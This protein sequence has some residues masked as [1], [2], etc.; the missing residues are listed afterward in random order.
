MT[1][2][3]KEYSRVFTIGRERVEVDY[4]DPTQV[5]I[6]APQRLASRIV[7]VRFRAGRTTMTALIELRRT[8][9]GSL[10]RVWLPVSLPANAEIVSLK[11]AD[12]ADL[13][14]RN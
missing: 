8:V 13:V 5:E 1:T 10:G 12:L 3:V 6:R 9:T 14:S 2:K 11:L 7:A 4:T